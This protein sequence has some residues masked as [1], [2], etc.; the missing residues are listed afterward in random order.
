MTLHR[1]SLAVLFVSVFGLLLAAANAES[2]RLVVTGKIV[3]G[4][5]YPGLGEL[6]CVGGQPVYDPYNPWACSP[7]TRIGRVRGMHDVWMFRDVEGTGANLLWGIDRDTENWDFS[8]IQGGRMLGAWG[9]EEVTIYACPY[10]FKCGVVGTWEG[11]W[12][13]T[14]KTTNL[15]FTLHGSSG[16]VEGLEAKGEA[17]MPEGTDYWVFTFHIQ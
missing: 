15:T 7:E 13:A 14:N 5:W 16:I 10:P 2:K 17:Y 6:T 3:W 1:I 9:T 12:N 8:P 11:T 4:G